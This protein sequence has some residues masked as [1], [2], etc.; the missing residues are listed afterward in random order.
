MIEHR[1][2]GQISAL[3]EQRDAAL[4]KVVALTGELAELSFD[5]QMCQEQL[6]AIAKQQ[7]SIQEQA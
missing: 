5:L 7:Q 2:Q 6:I 4:A 1:I 3:A